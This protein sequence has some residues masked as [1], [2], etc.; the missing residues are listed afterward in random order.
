MG[1]DRVSGRATSPGR[2]G[3]EHEPVL[4]RRCIC[5]FAFGFALLLALAAFAFGGCAIAMLTVAARMKPSR[6]L[7]GMVDICISISGGQGTCVEEQAGGGGGSLLEEIRGAGV[8]VQADVT[9][10]RP[11]KCARGIQLIPKVHPRVENSRAGVCQGC[12]SR[13][14]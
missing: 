9:R 8:Q 3:E 10:V 12:H 6:E 11:E 2:Y 5:V 13:P 1:V 14:N 4:E 7:G